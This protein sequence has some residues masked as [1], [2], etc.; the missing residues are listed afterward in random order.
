M[1]SREYIRLEGVT[2]LMK[3]FDDIPR[4]IQ[5]AGIRVAARKAFAP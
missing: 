5:I 3:T 2:E 1:A 4:Q